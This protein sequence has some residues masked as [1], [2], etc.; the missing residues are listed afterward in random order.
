MTLPNQDQTGSQRSISPPTL[1]M[2]RLLKS[3][4]VTNVSSPTP[5]A[6][7]L[8]DLASRKDSRALAATSTAVALSLGSP[9]RDIGDGAIV[10]GRDAGWQTAYGAARMAVEIAKESS[11]ALPPL[12]AVTGAVSILIRNY[13]VSVP[14]Y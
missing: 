9:L 14:Y 4:P 7:V 10:Q 13:D 6:K 8:K 3:K 12:K 5:P 11:D 2:R 1:I